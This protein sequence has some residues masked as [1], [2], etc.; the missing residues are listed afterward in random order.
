MCEFQK[1]TA[2]VFLYYFWGKKGKLDILDG[3]WGRE[4]RRKPVPSRPEH[5]VLY[6]DSASYKK[7]H[8]DVQRV[9][10]SDSLHCPQ[11][12]QS[13]RANELER[14]SS[15]HHLSLTRFPV[16]KLIISSQLTSFFP[17]N[18]HHH[19][20]PPLNLLLK[21]SG[22]PTR[23]QERGDCGAV[24]RGKTHH[25]LPYVRLY[26]PFMLFVAM[27]WWLTRLI[28]CISMKNPRVPALA[29]V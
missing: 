1:I 10:S 17:P 15:S 2:A 7:R 4:L 8:N 3:V 29:C 18:L 27:K 25:F 23:E 22:S 19:L 9:H 6:Y 14:A 26:W 12:C 13:H 20:T 5:N 21:Q 28:G 24:S 11:R 16:Q